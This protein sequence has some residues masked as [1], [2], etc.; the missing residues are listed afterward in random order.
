MA[1]GEG[2][3]ARRAFIIRIGISV[4]SVRAVGPH[5]TPRRGVATTWDI[6]FR[7]DTRCGGVIFYFWQRA[8]C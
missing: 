7:E 8:D 5:K 2:G 3:Q 4:K 6:P 1:T